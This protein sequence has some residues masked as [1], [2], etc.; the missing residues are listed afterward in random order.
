MG[1]KEYGEME[2]ASPKFT[3][4]KEF[5]EKGFSRIGEKLGE[6]EKARIDGK[7]MEFK[8]GFFSTL[9]SAAEN[10][11]EGVGKLFK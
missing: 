5:F 11:L 2:S 1:K 8:G 9:G 6:A 10:F 7:T 3:S 4:G